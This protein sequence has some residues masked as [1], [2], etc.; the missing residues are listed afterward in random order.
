VGHNVAMEMERMVMTRARSRLLH[1][2]QLS[3]SSS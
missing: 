3:R 1:G 2:R